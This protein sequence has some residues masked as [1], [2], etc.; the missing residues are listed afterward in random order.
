MMKEGEDEPKFDDIELKPKTSEVEDE[1]DARS[2]QDAS[3]LTSDDEDRRRDTTRKSV[4]SVE[5]KHAISDEDE[6]GEENYQI[7]K[8]SIYKPHRKGFLSRL[9]GGAPVA[10]TKQKYALS[11]INEI[12]TGEDV[13]AANPLKAS[14]EKPIRKGSKWLL[15]VLRRHHEELEHGSN[16]V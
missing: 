10:S 9:T 12:I 3:E 13:E 8:K 4:K 2:T 11:D 14:E 7:V 15:I 6:D 5:V 1:S 16:D